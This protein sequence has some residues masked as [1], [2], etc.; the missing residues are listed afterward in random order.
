[1]SSKPCCDAPVVLHS[2]QWLSE[3][4][5]GRAPRKANGSGSGSGSGSGEPPECEIA[6]KAPC[7]RVPWADGSYS[8]WSNL[9]TKHCKSA[10]ITWSFDDADSGTKMPQPGNFVF[11]SNGASV[12]YHCELWRECY[13]DDVSVCQS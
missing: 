9:M 11:G 4:S 5:A 3:S 6:F 2:Q 12:L 13:F 7:V 8:A 1:M 10:D